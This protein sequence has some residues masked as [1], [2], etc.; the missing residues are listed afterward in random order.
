MNVGLYATRLQAAVMRDREDAEAAYERYPDA[1]LFWCFV[2]LVASSNFRIA[3]GLKDGY[4]RGETFFSLAAS[5]IA[6]CADLRLL[7][8]LGD[9]V[10]L[11]ATTFRPLFESMILIDQVARQLAAVAGTR[12]F[13]FSIR[14]AID[15]G[16][17]KRLSRRHEDFLG[18]PI[19]RL[20]RI[21]SVRSPTANLLLSEEAYQPSRE[22]VQEYAAF[23]TTGDPIPLPADKSKGLTRQVFYRELRVD[24]S[25]LVEFRDHFV[26][27]R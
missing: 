8:E 25:L 9:A 13:P 10:L 12:Q 27:W 6:Q 22:I 20:S 26:P 11:S 16:P 2:D 15:F 17:A 19:D 4:V 3:N 5:T 23:L 18:T 14:A 7:K 21:M 24:P 1:T